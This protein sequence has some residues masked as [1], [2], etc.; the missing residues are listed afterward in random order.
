M[1]KHNI[2]A[3]YNHM[4]NRYGNSWIVEINDAVYELSPSLARPL[5]DNG[6]SLSKGVT[7][8]SVDDKSAIP[9]GEPNL[10]VRSNVRKM[11]ASIIALQD[12]NKPNSLDH[13]FHRANIRPSM[14]LVIKT[15]ESVSCSWR[16][17]RLLCSVKDAATQVS[18]A[19]RHAVE[20]TNKVNWLVNEEDTKLRNLGGLSKI[21]EST[22]KP[23]CL[24]LRSDGG[25]DRHPKHITVQIA[26]VY[27]LLALDLDCLVLLITA[28]DVSHT[29]EVEGCMPVANLALQNQ[30]FAR[31]SMLDEYETKFSNAQSGKKIREIV[32]KYEMNDEKQE[33]LHAWRE[34]LADPRRRVTDRFERMNYANEKAVVIPPATDEEIALAWEY[35]KDKVDPTIDPTKCNK[36]YVLDNNQ[37]LVE[38]LRKHVKSQRYHLEVRKCGDADCQTCTSV[39]SLILYVI[40]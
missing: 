4:L 33:T 10:P 2:D 19:M 5:S 29:N 7:K 1:R 11:H 22:T 28:R 9:V 21:P 38:F 23:Y 27:L 15:P 16:H 36:K 17:G 31:T 24:L 8:I 12:T 35:L 20:L 32:A 26:M 25:S 13:D 40:Y 39:S 18:T 3:H 37:L 14:A 30:A 34:S 6:L